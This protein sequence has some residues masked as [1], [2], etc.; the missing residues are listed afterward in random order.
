[1][2]PVMREIGGCFTLN[3]VYVPEMPTAARAMSGRPDLVEPLLANTG[4][5]PL[6]KVALGTVRG[7]LHDIG[8][9]P[10]FCGRFVCFQAL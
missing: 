6:G 8:K 4:R 3:E 9:R 1:M 7:D 10:G 2:I 5:K